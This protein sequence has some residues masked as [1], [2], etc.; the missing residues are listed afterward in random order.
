M[1][2]NLE[3]TLRNL[4]GPLVARAFKVEVRGA[5][6]VPRRGPVILVSL[7]D[8][9]VTRW[10]LRSLL[11]R[12]V[13]VVRASQGPAIDAQ[14]DAVEHLVTGGAIAFAGDQ[15]RPGFAILAGDAPLLP[16]E[17][18]MD[19]VSGQRTMFVGEPADVPESFAD[20][21]PA[22]LAS[23]RAASEWARQLVADFASDMRRRVP[24]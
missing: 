19:R 2:P 18:V 7:G 5:H 4:A 14:F 1:R 6:R 22:S 8:D 24:A 9:E 23:T 21:D 20:A 17:I 10:M 12:P 16:V 13:H 11:P 3:A 15:P